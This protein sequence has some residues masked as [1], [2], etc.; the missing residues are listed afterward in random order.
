MVNQS[1]PDNIPDRLRLLADWID[2]KTADNPNTE[3]QRDLRKWADRLAALFDAI[4]SG[5]PDAQWITNVLAK[6]E[7]LRQME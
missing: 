1:V 3:V 5:D 7:E 2:V 6:A 4:D